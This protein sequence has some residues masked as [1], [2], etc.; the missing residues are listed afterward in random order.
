MNQF[1]NIYPNFHKGFVNY[2]H[3][4][5]LKN[6]FMY[7][8]HRFYVGMVL[9]FYTVFAFYTV[10]YVRIILQNDLFRT[11]CVCKNVEKNSYA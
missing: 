10:I 7:D 11:L 3:R 4:N 6:G 5:L 8:L 1:S 2:S 9:I